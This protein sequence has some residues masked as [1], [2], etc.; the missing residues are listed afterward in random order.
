MLRFSANL[1]TLFQDLPPLE[2]PAAARRAGFA[3]VEIQ[4][5]YELPAQA[6][7]D[8]IARAGVE[9]A[10]FN[11][12]AGDLMQRGQGLA[13]VP[14]R[15]AAFAQ[16]LEQAV[17]YARVLRPLCVNVLAG[18]P[19]AALERERC[20]DV[21][22]GNLR[23]AAQAMEGEGVRVVT[24]AINRVD[25]PGSLVSTTGQALAAID[26]AGHANLRIQYD[27]YHMQIMEGD[28]IRTLRTHHERIG[29]IQFA[30]NPGRHE[31]GTGEINFAKVFAAI[32]ALPY[33]GYVGAEYLPTGRTEDSLGWLG[34]VA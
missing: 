5:P 27:L 30:D 9:V 24:E 29:H 6:W 2:R 32:E 18:V 8:A 11:V 17:D 14:G 25:R 15:E 19:D 1:S 21:L 34:T 7:H 12:P 22:A 31:P 4:F 33:A 10:L 13:A 16:A 20:L 28:L 3:A 23:R 26:R